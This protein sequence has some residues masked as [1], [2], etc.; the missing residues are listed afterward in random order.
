VSTYRY[1]AARTDGGIVTGLVEA[2][3]LSAAGERVAGR[4]LLPISLSAAPEGGG[5]RA[6]RRAELAVAFR[7]VATLVG[8]GVPLVKAVHA[9]LPLTRGALRVALEGTARELMEGQSLARSLASQDLGFPPVLL[10]IVGAGERSG[11]L[12]TALDEAAAQLE[13][14]AELLARVRQALAYPLVLLATGTASVVI[15][16]LV[17]VPRFA[18]LLGELGQELPTST[19]LLLSLTSGTARW[20]PFLLAAGCAGAVLLTRLARSPAGRL[21]WHGWLLGL[22][23]VGPIRHGLAAGRFTQS[24]SALLGS[25]TPMLA[26][27]DAAGSHVGDA[28]VGAR[29]AEARERVAEGQPLAGSLERTAALPAVTTQLLAVGEASGEL[30]VMAARAGRLAVADAE[31]RLQAAVALLEPAIIL[32]FGASVALVALAL[33]QAV[34]AVRPL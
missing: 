34:Y 18:A 11:R 10:G 24:L 23:L 25:G 22:P 2:T 8:V 27:L 1:R 16:G 20:G 21:R 5:K 14:E 9:T 12:A 19:R 13:R 32:G 28:A 4:G 29:V 26:A 6:A 3:S 33:F 15:I 17:I 30:A 31:R 7:S